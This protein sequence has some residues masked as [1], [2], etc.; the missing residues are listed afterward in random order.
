MF[1]RTRY[2]WATTKVE[3]CLKF[4]IDVPDEWFERAKFVLATDEFFDEALRVKKAQGCD[5]FEAI[6]KNADEILNVLGRNRESASSGV[7]FG[8]VSAAA[9]AAVMAKIL[10]PE[11]GRQFLI[12]KQDAWDEGDVGTSKVE[13]S[14]IYEEA[15]LKAMEENGWSDDDFQ[16][17][18][19]DISQWTLGQAKELAGHFGIADGIDHDPWE[20]NPL[21]Q[22]GIYAAKI[23]ILEEMI[24]DLR[25][26]IGDSE[27]E[28]AGVN[29]LHV[30]TLTSIFK[31][32]AT[33]QIELAEAV[34]SVTDLEWRPE[35]AKNVHFFANNLYRLDVS[36]GELRDGLIAQLREMSQRR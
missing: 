19:Q 26:A 34:Y 21:V 31:G 15:A 18:R 1:D 12:A 10:T 25:E 2:N 24:D 35:M 33:R 5:W 6:S 28:L 13:S 11:Q 16:Q 22:A 4:D 36:D 27:H 14:A 30:M 9:G 32:A 3:A 8:V 23:R 17:V 7:Y 29:G 20:L